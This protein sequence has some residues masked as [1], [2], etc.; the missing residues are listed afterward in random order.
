MNKEEIIILKNSMNKLKN[1]C[2][3]IIKF[4]TAE[5]KNQ[6]K[7]YE[8]ENK[9]LYSH[10]HVKNFGKD[11]FEEEIV[12]VMFEDDEYVLEEEGVKVSGVTYSMYDTDRSEFIVPFKWLELE[13]EGYEEDITIK[14]TQEIGN[15]VGQW[16]AAQKDK[17]NIELEKVKGILKVMPKEQ[18]FKLIKEMDIN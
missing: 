15:T 10:L 12:P 3:E 14:L 11:P 17:T 6:I 2:E 7:C 1:K 4:Y 9:A 8:D 5:Y 13:K 18:L 16:Y